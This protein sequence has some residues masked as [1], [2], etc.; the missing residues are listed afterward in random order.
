M[1]DEDP[2]QG[3]DAENPGM[4]LRGSPGLLE[5]LTVSDDEAA[6]RLA[7]AWGDFDISLRMGEGFNEELF[8]RLKEVLQEC[9][10]A[11]R[12]KDSIPRLG[13]NVMV[14]FFGLTE[15]NSHLYD[16]ATARQIMDAAYELHMMVAECVA[17]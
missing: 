2:T 11:W 14:D 15:G 9:T 7:R 3:L 5:V 8:S 17:L 6:G 16:E 13:A 12:G 4:S 1:S 10:E